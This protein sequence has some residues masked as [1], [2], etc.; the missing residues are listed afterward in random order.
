MIKILRWK[1][2]VAY[3]ND[4][5]RFSWSTAITFESGRANRLREQFFNRGNSKKSC[6][7]EKNKKRQCQNVENFAQ[8]IYGIKKPPE[9]GGNY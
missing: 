9:T 3:I 4:T 5:F 2:Q 8:H 1:K 6:L 7:H